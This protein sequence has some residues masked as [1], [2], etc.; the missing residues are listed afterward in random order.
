[1]EVKIANTPKEIID[2]FKIREIV[3]IEG[4]NVPRDLELDGLDKVATLIVVYIDNLAIGAGRY[5]LLKDYAKIER[6][7]VL[8]EYRGNGVGKAIIKFIEET[9]KENTKIELLKLNSQ[10]T[11]VK[12]YEKLNFLKKGEIFIEAGIEHIQMIKAI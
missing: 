9:I 12:F 2:N 5:R 11:S 3:F 1:M 7:A 4:Q 6:I 10:C 8:E